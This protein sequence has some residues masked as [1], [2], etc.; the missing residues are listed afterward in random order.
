VDALAE[1]VA[2]LKEESSRKVVL[3]LSDGEDF[4]SRMSDGKD[5]LS[6]AQDDH[7]MV[8]AIGMRNRYFNGAQWTI[9]T[10]DPF[11]RKL[12][13]Q[14]GGGNFDISKA[15]ELNSTFTRV[16]DELHRQYLIG[17]APGVLDGKLHKL[18]L[19]IKAPGMTARAP[20]EL[21]G[22]ERIAGRLPIAPWLSGS[23]PPRWRPPSS[24]LNSNSHSSGA[25]SSP[26]LSTRRCST[27]P[28]RSC[29]TSPA[30]ISR[31]LMT[32]ASRN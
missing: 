6:R 22:H 18:D 31:S 14:T 23:P 29:A 3:V 11:L 1:S 27:M 9:S 20:P 19:R 13:A 25:A 21:H 7:V 8:Y 10:P 4:G 12:T 24:W 5:V 17:I 32:G 26:S 30:R 2:Q 16:A 15:T 28:T